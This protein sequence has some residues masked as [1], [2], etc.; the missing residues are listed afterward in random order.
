M[1]KW[2]FYPFEL[3]AGWT[4]LF[5]GL[6]AIVTTAVVATAGSIHLD[7]VIDL[8]VT[9][10]VYLVTALLEGLINWLCMSLFAYLAGRI[11][12]RSS[13]RLLDVVGTQAL[14]RAPFLISVLVSLLCF[15]DNILQYLNY[16]FMHEGEPAQIGISDVVLFACMVVAIILMTVWAIALMYKAYSVSC[17]VKGIRGILSFTVALIFAEILSKVMISFI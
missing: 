5:A 8:H 6:L 3:V 15:N 17:N 11:F 2:L 16:V 9:N 7:G 4:A 14:A 12:S 13:I 1:K 10:E